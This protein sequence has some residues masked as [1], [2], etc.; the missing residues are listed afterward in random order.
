MKI[1][2]EATL[3]DW[4][5]VEDPASEVH[6]VSVL[7]NGMEIAVVPVNY[8]TR[9]GWCPATLDEPEDAPV[10]DHAALMN[11]TCPKCGGILPSKYAHG[12]DR[13][14]YESEAQ[15]IIVETLTPYITGRLFSNVPLGVTA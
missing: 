13:S 5:D 4:E 10:L 6:R 3:V 15:R 11:A 14:Y 2:M 12:D 7:M 8:R 9:E 1:E